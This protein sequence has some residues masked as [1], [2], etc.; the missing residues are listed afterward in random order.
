M[1]QTYKI[2][3]CLTLVILVLSNIFWVYQTIDNAVG[4]TYYKVSCEEYYQDML[5][6]KQIVETK[7]TRKEAINFLKINKIKYESFQKGTEYIIIFN[8]FA[9]VY[10]E[11]WE[12]ISSEEN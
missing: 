5:K 4:H 6:F 3:F 11:K 7:S 9:L 12:L 10:D 1:K 2:R 8:S